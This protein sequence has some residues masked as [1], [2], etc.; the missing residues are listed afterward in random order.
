M[1]K[2]KGIYFF[3]A[4]FVLAFLALFKLYSPFLM[5]LLI[6]FLLFLATQIIHQKILIKVKSDFLASS[7]MIISFLLVCL[8][9]LA[10]IISTLA[11]MAKNLD[12]GSFH[13]FLED[14]K[15]Q[16]ITFF[17]W[18]MEYLPQKITHELTLI[19]EDLQQIDWT[20][21]SQR[22]L[23]IFAEAGK[24]GVSFMSDTF[25]ILAFLFFFYYY[26][27]RLG[28]Y[29]LALIPID[30]QQVKLLYKEVSA[31]ISIVFYS[32]ILS[33]ILQG[34]LFG[35]LML[36]Y[37]YDNA[38][39]LGMFYGI[40][41]LVPVVGGALVWLPIVGY[42]FYLGHTLNAI[43]IALYSIIVIATLADNGVKPFLITFINRLLLKTSV[44]I[45]EMLIF[46]AIIAGLMSFGFWGIVLG[47]AIT[48]LFL[49][50]LR[51]Y[52]NLYQEQS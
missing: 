40:A 3:F 52:K 8:L 24:N 2:A 4:V 26:S 28:T 43:I 35:I 27:R 21:V 46:F 15:N 10:Y 42:E 36:L 12:L 23:G 6:A 22:G 41:S 48:A 45:N 50:L 30:S 32:S 20:K 14:C 29:L 49:A 33:M 7:L 39:L 19:I 11:V 18:L 37:G 16:A 9:P 51:I 1:T 5:D 38:F 47:P 31:V 17:S 34:A 44:E 13:L 25:F